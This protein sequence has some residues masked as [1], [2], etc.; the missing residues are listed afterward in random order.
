MAVE[1]ARLQSINR[2]SI[3]FSLPQNISRKISPEMR[4]A[5]EEKR[6]P[7]KGGPTSSKSTSLIRK[8]GLGILYSEEITERIIIECDSLSSKL[9]SKLKP[10]ISLMVVE[11]HHEGKLFNISY[12]DSVKSDSLPRCIYLPPKNPALYFVYANIEI[13]GEKKSLPLYQV[14]VY[15]VFDPDIKKSDEE[16]IEAIFNNIHILYRPK[17]LI[18]KKEVWKRYNGIS[19]SPSPL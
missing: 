14:W 9:K 13:Q 15:L 4:V 6:V 18:L 19:D 8:K 17:D 7:L 11:K 3:Q 12:S 10:F 5:F 2:K 16:N 1:I